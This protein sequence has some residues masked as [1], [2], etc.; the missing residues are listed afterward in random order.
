MRPFAVTSDG[1]LRSDTAVH[2]WVGLLVYWLTNRSSELFP[3]PTQEP[4][5]RNYAN[6]APS[7]A[8][9]WARGRSQV[10]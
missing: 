1:L 9:P 5:E 2:E 3:G 4:V 8:L 6:A 10:A 7:S